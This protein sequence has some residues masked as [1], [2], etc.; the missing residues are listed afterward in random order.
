MKIL[1]KV[2]YKGTQYQGWQKQVDVPSIQE[3]IESV[4]S[5]ILNEEISIQGSGRTDAGVHAV[6]QYFHFVTSKDDTDLNRLKY[7][8]NC[9][10][11][12]DIF[13]QSFVLVNDDF[14]ARYDA[15]SK[16]YS[17]FIRL[18]E[19]VVFNYDIEATIPYEIDLKKLEEAV[20]CFKGKHNFQDFNSKE[21]DENNFVRE[22]YDVK[23]VHS[24]VTNQVVITFKGDGFM[25]YQIRDM[26]GTAL[27]VASGKEDIL[28]IQKHLKDDKTRNIVS[29]KAP[30]SGLFLVD[31]EY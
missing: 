19:R 28:F 2:S 21:E 8:V 15:K 4:L 22:I 25:R 10:L 27:A 5:K 16:T 6:G 20:Q 13:I 14:H 7:S 18:G 29:Y 24:Q 12:N 23:F 11:P 31:V 9:L 17:Y 30:A 26:I 1:A 3:N